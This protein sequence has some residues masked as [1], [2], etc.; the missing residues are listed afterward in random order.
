MREVA[1]PE[2]PG[3]QLRGRAGNGG[4]CERVKTFSISLHGLLDYD[5]TDR[6]EPTFELSVFAECFH[7]MLAREYGGIMFSGLVAE[8]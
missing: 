5:E 8:R 6:D 2:E 3:L 7:D 1:L 4:A